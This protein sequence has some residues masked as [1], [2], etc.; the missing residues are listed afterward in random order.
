MLL[1]EFDNDIWIENLWQELWRTI[2][3]LSS[4]LYQMTTSVC[5]N[6]NVLTT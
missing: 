1:H 4:H 5:Q 2:L 6:R 3:R